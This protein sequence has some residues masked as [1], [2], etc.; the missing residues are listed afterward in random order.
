VFTDYKPVKPGIVANNGLLVTGAADVKLKTVR[1]MVQGKIES[2]E[3]VFW[4]VPA[5]APM[6]EQ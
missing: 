4:R 3:G 5:G 1:A 2:S 6:S